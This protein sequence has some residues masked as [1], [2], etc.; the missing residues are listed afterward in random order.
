MVHFEKQIVETRTWKD[1][2]YFIY[3]RLI[4]QLYNTKFTPNFVTLA[5]NYNHTCLLVV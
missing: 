2:I 3:K 1:R 4:I 5:F